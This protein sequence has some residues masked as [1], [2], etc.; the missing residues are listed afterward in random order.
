[1]TVPEPPWPWTVHADPA[2]LGAELAA[3]I[4]MRYLEAR[5][6]ERPFLLGCPGGRTPRPIYA[7][8]ARLGGVL[9]VDWSG[10]HIVMMDDYLVRDGDR[11]VACPA[12]A[13]FSCRRF[14]E[15][16][17]VG[18]LDEGRA[19]ARRVGRLM[20]P[21]P[22]APADYD[23]AIDRLGG[24]DVFIVASGA[25]DGHVAFN[26]PG[27]AAD[28]TTRIVPLAETTRRDNLKTFPRFGSIDE[29]PT[30]GLTVGLATIAAAREVMMVLHGVEKGLSLRRLLD[31]EDFDPAWPATI[32]HRCGGAT[33]HVDRAAWTAADRV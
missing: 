31:A 27:T 28:S 4:V 17:I 26:P 3:A 22:Q 10:L 29:V 32:L 11:M 9:D 6:A 12:D 23:Q 20:M 19:P 30:H 18:L 14:A 16:E 13:H 21:D 1:M 24:I 8:M 15:L 33:L 5:T 2:A 7:E 25:S